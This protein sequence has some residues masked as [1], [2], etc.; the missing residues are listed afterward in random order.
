MKSACAP[1][2]TPANKLCYAPGNKDQKMTVAAVSR[3]LEKV[4]WG[5]KMQRDR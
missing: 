3:V 2:G 5:Q 4:V 1:Y